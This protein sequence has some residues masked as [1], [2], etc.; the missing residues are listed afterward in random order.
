MPTKPLTLE[1]Q[2]QQSDRSDTSFSPTQEQN[3]TS[4]PTDSTD[5]L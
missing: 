2:Q 5:Q 3:A 1:R 4:D